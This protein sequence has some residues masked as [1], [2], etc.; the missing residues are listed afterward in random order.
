[1][2]L[3]DLVLHNRSHRRFD[4]SAPLDR[5]TLVE[6][7]NLARLTPSAANKQPLKYFISWT[8]DMNAAIFPHLGW[9]GYLPNWPG[10]PE[11]ERPTAYIL[12]LAD[13]QLGNL[14]TWD[15]GIAAQTIALC[16][17]ERGLGGCMIG[18]IQR[19]ALMKT[20]GIAPDRY[21][22]LLVIALGK[23]IEQVVLETVTD[24]GDI[25]YWRDAEQVHHVPKRALEEV[26]L[27]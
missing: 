8:P 17:T 6:L 27:N 7:V 2:S 5:E 12:I 26:L 20:L 14:Y 3:R 4:E 10:P 23:P 22:L 18:S 24:D 21:E 19:E 15:Q 16:A 11:G 25:R 1:M 13:K 9:A